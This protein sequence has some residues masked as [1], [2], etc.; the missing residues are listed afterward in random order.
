[1]IICRVQSLAKAWSALRL[2]LYRAK[3]TKYLRERTDI[4]LQRR[5]L[6]E[7]SSLVDPNHVKGKA[8]HKK[9]LEITS[10][11]AHFE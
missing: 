5:A 2:A 10:L 11:K 6:G 1:V 4:A 3:C 8:L 9:L 7:W